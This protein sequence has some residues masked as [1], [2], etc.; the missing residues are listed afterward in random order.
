MLLG[1]ILVFLLADYGDGPAIV[2]YE[3]LGARQEV[4]HFDIQVA[5]RS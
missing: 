4:L 2:P 1:E 3:G 5:A